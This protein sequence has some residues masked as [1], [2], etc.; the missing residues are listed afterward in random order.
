ME[1]IM[2]RMW[3]RRQWG[4]AILAASCLAINVPRLEAE[5]TA[6][7]PFTLVVMDPLALPLACD[8]VEGYAQRE[9]E[10]LGEFLGRQLNR[11]VRVVFAQSLEKALKDN[12]PGGADLVIGKHS[13]VLA[14]A[15]RLKLRVSPLASLT[16]SD[17]ETTQTGLIVVHRDDPAKSVDQLAG[18]RIFF[19]PAD[20]DEKSAAPMRLL[21]QHDV[22]LPAEIE[23][24]PACSDG[25]AKLMELD[26]DV[27]VAA[28][29]SSYAQPLLEG[30][31]T[32]KKGDLRVIGKTQPVPFITAFVS[33]QLPKD[34]RDQISAALD[35]VQY[36]VNLL[37]ALETRQ[38]FIPWEEKEPSDEGSV[39]AS[40]KKP[41]P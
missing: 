7:A 28:V 37:I 4:W 16:G 17:G 38:G 26:R 1:K 23:T 2:G 34:L 21:K 27:R 39:A 3:S 33:E 15:K 35:E 10:V 24:V 8:C 13:V 25:A 14:D 20:C 6:A 11:D 9:Y 32:I 36:E 19:G 41:Q 5:Q 40:K 31:G 30:C 12:A 22:A 18:Y 29:I